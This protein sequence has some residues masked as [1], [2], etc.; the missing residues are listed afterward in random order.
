MSFPAHLLPLRDCVP[1]L[2]WYPGSRHA[3]RAG[4]PRIADL[5]FGNPHDMPLPQYVAALAHQVVPQNKDWYAYKMSE[6]I[7]TR[8]VAASLRARTGLEFAHED[9]FMTNGGFAA[10]AVSLRVCAGPGDEVIFLSPPW[11][12]YEMLI[13]ATGA[14][15][16]RV[17]LQAPEFALDAEAIAAAITPRTS[18][19]I[20]NSPNNPSGRIYG[21]AEL[22]QLAEVLRT[23]SA[24]NGRPIALLSDEAYYKIAFDGAAV[25]TPATHYAQTCVLYS[26]G[27][28]LL[29]PGQ[30]IGYIALPPTHPQR[31]SMREAMM[32]AQCATGFAFPN[33]LLQHALPEIEPLCVD[34]SVLARR[35]DRVTAALRAQGYETTFPAST[36]YV[37]VRSPD[38]DDMAFAERLAERD[39]F[40]LPGKLVE[41]PGFIRIS[42]TASDAMLEQALETFARCAT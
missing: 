2:S 24:R 1:F 22:S 5:F 31:E 42:L 39:T 11:F 32:L 34:L 19:I 21:D 8:T 10:I 35:R 27:K 6:E 30:R 36:F 41:L 16:V 13:R 15:A 14:A 40:V 29:A 37:L 18:A 20:V 17:S 28:Q 3:Q 33:A 4:D 12:F 38:T 23:A 26:Y 25:P 9:V 7:A